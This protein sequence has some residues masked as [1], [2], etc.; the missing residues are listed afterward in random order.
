M[1]E[2]DEHEG[3][4]EKRERPFRTAEAEQAWPRREREEERNQVE[5]DGIALRE[6]AEAEEEARDGSL[7]GDVLLERPEAEDDAGESERHERR[8]D[9]R[10]PRRRDERRKQRREGAREMAGGLAPAAPDHALEDECAEE[11][12]DR[13]GQPDRPFLRP[14]NAHHDGED[15]W[16]EDRRAPRRP[17]RRRR[18]TEQLARPACDEVLR[19]D[20]PA[21]LVGAEEVRLPEQHEPQQGAGRER[22]REED[23]PGRFGIV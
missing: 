15:P 18:E 4:R 10:R 1:G 12:E 8:L 11:P 5:A 9:G 14:E 22:G 21:P 19:A 13:G 20:R 6:E 2:A 17:Q 16:K 7:E 3:R 23:P